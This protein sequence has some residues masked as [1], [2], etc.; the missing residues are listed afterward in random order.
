LEEC[1]VETATHIFRLRTMHCDDCAALI[2]DTLR[3]LPGVRNA[4]ATL[5]TREIRVE[6]DP[7]QTSPDTVSAAITDLGFQLKSP[8][9]G[10]AGQP[11]GPVDPQVTDAAWRILEPSF[12]DRD[13]SHAT[14]TRH[15]FE[16]IAYKVRNDVP[17]RDVPTTFGA[18]QTLY[19][20][21]ARWRKDG[22]WERV[23]IAARHSAFAD[24]L[25]WIESVGD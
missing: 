2:D 9:A 12:Q 16:G 1:T 3:E 4:D 10:R 24:E 14:R 7:L 5:K 8:P 17:W 25:A 11:V 19:A 23:A 22:T 18:W 6:L 21:L 13:R 15:L 20:R